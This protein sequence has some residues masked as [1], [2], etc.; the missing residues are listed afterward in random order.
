MDYFIR[1]HYFFI[2]CKEY[3]KLIKTESIVASLSLDSA[4]QSID[5]TQ[6][7]SVMGLVVGGQDADPN[8]FPHM[9][10]IG[11]PN[12]NG[13]ISFNC[14]GSLISDRFVLT[15]AHCAKS[16]R[17]SPTTIRL[18]DLNLKLNDRNLPEIDIPVESFISHERYNSSSKENDIALIKMKHS[19]PFS[20]SIRPACIHQTENIG[21]TRALATGWG[22]KYN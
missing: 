16:E 2:E 17:K 6:C 22:N 21:K 20:K 10:A 19:V 14:G 4:S 8:E 9:V 1:R 11:Y 15:A 18:G 13:E 5:T 7:D 12:F 3:A